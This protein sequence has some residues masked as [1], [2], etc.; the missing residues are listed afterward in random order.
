MYKLYVDIEEYIQEF[1]RFEAHTQLGKK[2]E[3]LKAHMTLTQQYLERALNESDLKAC[4]KNIIDQSGLSTQAK[5][6]VYKAFVNGIYLHDLGKINPAFQWKKMHNPDFKDVEG[7]TSDSKHSMLSTF[8]YYWIMQQEMDKVKARDG[9]DPSEMDACDYMVYLFGYMI[10]KHHGQLDSLIDFAYRWDKFIEQ[11]TNNT[12]EIKTKLEGLNLPMEDILHEMYRSYIEKNIKCIDAKSF[13]EGQN[14]VLTRLFY[15]LLITCDYAATGEFVSEV[16]VPIHEMGRLQDVLKECLYTYRHSGL[17]QKIYHYRQQGAK[18]TPKSINDLRSELFLE[19]EQ[20]YIQEPNQSIYYLE[21]PTGSGKTNTSLNLALKMCEKN[22]ATNKLLYI[23]PF[24]TLIEQTEQALIDA[25]DGVIKPQVL[26][27]ITPIPSM[28]PDEKANDYNKEYM[29][30][31]FMHYPLVVTT[32][33]QFFKLLFDTKKEANIPFAKLVNSVVIIDEIQSYSIRLWKEIIHFFDLYGKLLNMK[34]IIMSAT[35][36]KLNTLLDTEVASYTNLIKNPE[37][38]FLHPVFKNRV[39]LDYSLVDTPLF[40]GKE[41]D[42]EQLLA[43]IVSIRE[44]RGPTK[45]LVEFLTVKSA[46]FFYDELIRQRDKLPQRMEIL[47]LTGRDNRSTRRHILEQVKGNLLDC[48]LVTTQVI[49]AGV[50]I[51]MDVGYKSIAYLDADEQ[52]LGRVNRS[53][54]KEGSVVYFFDMDE[55]KVIYKKD[56]RMQFNLR[57]EKY[58]QILLEKDFYQFYVEVLQEVQRE[59]EQYNEA[60]FK[61]VKN[62]VQM[63]DYQ[64]IHQHMALIEEKD[65]ITLFINTNEDITIDGVSATIRGDEVWQNYKDLLEDQKIPY[66]KKQIKLSYVRSQ[67]DYFCYQIYTPKMRNGYRRQASGFQ[68]RIGD[69]LYLDDGER[70]IKDGH[71]DLME[72]MKLF[73][74]A[75]TED[76]FM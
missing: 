7:R 58:R 25:L 67:M 28:H 32:H 50:D 65:T 52:F 47:G 23:F 1:H 31:L 46:M 76:D 35:L 60:N 13:S 37:T 9:L 24:N 10:S 64:G 73:E 40:L 57:M 53:C 3:K 66:A 26:N 36:P 43:H 42:F 14:Y 4:I 18:G 39:K 69:L 11:V 34:L 63:L 55:A 17:Y 48:I 16:Y 6:F 72:A 22:K 49:E 59:K 62:K 5:D 74:D 54:K 38:Y 27:S 8:L 2:A 15:S 56:H 21:A 19:A 61:H 68:D 44:E 12:L 41:K 75:F 20:S 30:F 51:D 29:N 45:I 33:V 71:F 70:Y